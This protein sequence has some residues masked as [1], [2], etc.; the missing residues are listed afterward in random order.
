MIDNRP[1]FLIVC[2]H[3]IRGGQLDKVAWLP[4]MP[5]LL[6]TRGLPQ[7]GRRDWWFVNEGDDAVELFD[8]DGNR[9]VD[10]S[11]LRST[12]D[13]GFISEEPTRKAFEI[14]CPVARCSRR[15]YRSDAD[16]LQTLFNLIATDA[17]FRGAVAVS[18]TDAQ[19]TVR[20]DVLHLARDTAR[21][22]FQ[23]NV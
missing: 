1:H 7:T 21:T 9:R 22:R 18:A 16:R 20:L 2:D 5:R 11:P 10:W 12:W 8:L 13:K 19:I 15:A 14:P 6:E 4:W 3:G 17:Q 23:L